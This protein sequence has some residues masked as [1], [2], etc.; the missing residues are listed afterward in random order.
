MLTAINK[1]DFLPVQWCRQGVHPQDEYRSHPFCSS[2]QIARGSARV[3]SLDEMTFASTRCI[4]GSQH[5][6]NAFAVWAR[7]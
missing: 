7:L 4:L 2:L 1:I 3:H 5:V 6:H